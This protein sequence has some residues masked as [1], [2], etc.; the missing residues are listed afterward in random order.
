MPG[1]W[2]DVAE[3][4]PIN[5]NAAF[6][7]LIET[8]EQLNERA[9]ASAIFAHDGNM[10]TTANRERN[11]AQYRRLG[12]WIAKR[13]PLHRDRIA[14]RHLIDSGCL[15]HGRQRH[16]LL[17]VCHGGKGFV[18]HIIC[19]NDAVHSAHH[20]P[21]HLLHE[22]KLPNWLTM[23]HDLQHHPD[24]RHYLCCCLDNLSAQALPHKAALVAK[25]PQPIFIPQCCSLAK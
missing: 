8:S 5:G 3:I 11:I 16:K 14:Q 21:H 9:L 22:H 12:A 2:A 19:T 4:V 24:K 7:G 6:A 17:V 1:R 10:L 25:H 23:R 18:D 13:H 15:A 20:S